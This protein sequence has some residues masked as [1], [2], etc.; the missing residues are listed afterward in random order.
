MSQDAKT[1]MKAA[2]Q[3][4]SGPTGT[5][6]RKPRR[7]ARHVWWWAVAAAVLVHGAALGLLNVKA[8]VATSHGPG[9]PEVDW[10]GEKTTGS[11]S[12]LGVQLALFDPEPLFLPTRWNYA[13]VENL[14][15]DIREPGE[16]FST[17][18]PQLKVKPLASPP[19]L[20]VNPA[21]LES[22]KEA[23]ATF[24][25]PYL[26]GFGQVDPTYAQVQ[27]RLA[28]IEVRSL[29]TGEIVSRETV[30][31]SAAAAPGDWPWWD[32]FE[33]LVTVDPTGVLG[34]P[35]VPWPGSGTEVVDSFFR[36]Y[37]RT[38]MHL[39]LKLKPGTYRV[40]IGP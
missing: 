15:R 17:Y 11:E 12:V 34:L 16:I 32:P 25:A 5:G 36:G 40:L 35:L 1:A 23:A 20:I 29:A 33:A 13:S 28:V 21:G 30:P 37:L 27:Q 3:G 18:E 10:V 2:D 19:G 26:A 38:A 9:G 8:P 31:V 7:S 4:K 24:P 22:P 14:V 6:G 39:D